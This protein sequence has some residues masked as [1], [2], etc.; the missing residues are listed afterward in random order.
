VA[1][2]LLALGRDPGR[3][4]VDAD[5]LFARSP[6]DLLYLG[7]LNSALRRLLQSGFGTPDGEEVQGLTSCSSS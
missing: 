7:D 2:P 6:T 4:R 5:E 3:L 1:S